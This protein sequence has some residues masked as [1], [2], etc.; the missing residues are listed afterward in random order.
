MFTNALRRSFFAAAML[1]V[2][3]EA[4][5]V[6]I[7]T[8]TIANPG[9]AAD[10]TS[11][12]SVAY[13]YQI[14]KFEVTAGQYCAFLNA[15][16]ATD[17]YGLY[18]GY[19]G[20]WWGCKIYQNGSGGTYTYTVASDWANR[21]VNFVSWGD[22]ARFANWLSNGQPTGAQGTATTEDGSYYLNGAVTTAALKSVKRKAGATWVIPTEDEWYKAAYYDLDKSG[23]AGYWLYSTRSND[24]PSNIGA[25]GYTDPGN[26][27][28]YYG[29]SSY[30]IGAPYY[31]TI[32]GEF[33]NSASA[34][35]TFDQ[36][37]NEPEWT[38]TATIGND[39]CHD[40]RGG[41]YNYI[42][43]WLRS[44]NYMSFDVAAYGNEVGFRVAL[45][46]EPGSLILLASGAAAVLIR[47]R[48]AK[49]N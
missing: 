37:G 28:N 40:V 35:G 13:T 1:V 6:T 25:D 42:A 3:V 21:P 27:A 12:G 47:R 26:H 19:M 24:L 9:N 11:Y 38:D 10:T 5:A 22:A 29:N 39:S 41:S 32:V 4:Q 30:T 23:G 18:H 17:T 16:A 33:E 2:A 7:D 49:K 15:V 48:R 8:V 46:P 34:Y 31:R 20:E 43:D 36:G 45:V 44:S 14:G